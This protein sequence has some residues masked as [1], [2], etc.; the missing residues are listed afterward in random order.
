VTFPT[1]GNGGK[2]DGKDGDQKEGAARQ[3]IRE[4]KPEFTKL[5]KLTF[6]EYR[7]KATA[8]LQGCLEGLMIHAENDNHT[9]DLIINQIAKN[10]KSANF[11]FQKTN[12][13]FQAARKEL[14]EV[15]ER[16]F[17]LEHCVFFLLGE[18]AK[19]IGKP[20]DGKQLNEMAKL[21]HLDPDKLKGKAKPAIA[22][23]E[24]R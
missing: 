20:W 10:S 1:R 16:L 9:R 14:D 13:N 24:G 15:F 17:Q 18:R 21:F 22:L 4:Q 6:E 5:R 3:M 2:A 23:E 12:S 7:K 11:L 8:I 19:G